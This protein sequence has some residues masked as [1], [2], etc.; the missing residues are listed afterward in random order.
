MVQRRSPPA[1]LAVVLLAVV[2]LAVACHTPPP[3]QPSTREAAPAAQPDVLPDSMLVEPSP[4]KPWPSAPSDT[5]PSGPSMAP[6]ALSVVVAKWSSCALLENGTVWCWGDEH[7]GTVGV[8]DGWPQQVPLTDVVQLEAASGLA[9]ARTRSGSNCPAP[10]TWPPTAAT[11]APSTLPARSA[12]GKQT[13]TC[14]ASG[15]LDQPKR[16]R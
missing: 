14:P 11:S 8:Q 7:D 4:L 2:L 1:L 3:S 9:V 5:G 6:A 15:R 12:V 16:S 13:A 10:C